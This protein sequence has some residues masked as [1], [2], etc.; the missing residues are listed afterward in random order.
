MVEAIPA[1]IAVLSLDGIFLYY[2]RAVGRVFLSGSY[3]EWFTEA[4]ISGKSFI[5]AMWTS[6]ARIQCRLPIRRKVVVVAA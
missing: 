4:T 2:E 3:P 6:S 1:L 5:Q